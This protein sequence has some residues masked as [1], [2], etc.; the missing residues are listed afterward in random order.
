MRSKNILKAKNIW[1]I[2]K[3]PNKGRLPTIRNHL[4]SI[5]NIN[6]GKTSHQEKEEKRNKKKASQLRHG[7]CRV[8]SGTNSNLPKSQKILRNVEII[9]Y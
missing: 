8:N 5:K 6:L 9:D 3:K 7:I 4:T 2:A 1:F